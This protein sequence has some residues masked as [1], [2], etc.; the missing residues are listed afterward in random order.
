VFNR[1]NIPD[2]FQ[3]AKAPKENFVVKSKLWKQ[4]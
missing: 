4:L 2:L 3:A 1:P